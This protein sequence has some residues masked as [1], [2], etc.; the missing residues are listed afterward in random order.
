MESLP[1]NE[2][3]ANVLTQNLPSALPILARRFCWKV[4][5]CLLRLFFLRFWPQSVFCVESHRRHLRKRSNPYPS[6]IGPPK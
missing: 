4:A 3:A 6:I 2:A 5:S 1:H